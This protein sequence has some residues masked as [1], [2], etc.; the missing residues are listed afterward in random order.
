MIGC[1]CSSVNKLK[2]RYPL[3]I[4]KHG[5]ERGCGGMLNIWTVLNN[6]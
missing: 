3:E 2:G 4:K 5:K 1:N 6:Y